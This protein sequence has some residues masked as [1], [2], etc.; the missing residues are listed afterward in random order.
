MVLKGYAAQCSKILAVAM[1]SLGAGAT[2]FAPGEVVER[3]CAACH[4]RGIANAPRIDQV[5][6]WQSRLEMSSLEEIIARGWAG[7]RR[8]PPKGYCTRCTE[9]DFAAAV[10]EMLPE[11]LLP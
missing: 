2:E 7:N 5:S 1:L 10:Q 3:F 8:M 6:D 9:E 11:Q 4:E